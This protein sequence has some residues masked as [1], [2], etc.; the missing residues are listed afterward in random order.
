MPLHMWRRAHQQTSS[1]NA[2]PASSE[3]PR[4]AVELV[5]YLSKYSNLCQLQPGSP[6]PWEIHIGTKRKPRTDNIQNCDTCTRT[7][8]WLKGL[9]KSTSRRAVPL[10]NAM[11]M[12]GRLVLR[13][14]RSCPRGGATPRPRLRPIRVQASVSTR[15]ASGERT[16]PPW[17]GRAMF[18]D[19]SSWIYVPP[20][21]R[22]WHVVEVRV[23]EA[24]TQLV[25]HVARVLCTGDGLLSGALNLAIRT[26]LLFALMKMGAKKVMKTTAEKKGVPW[27]RRCQELE[28]SEVWL[29]PCECTCR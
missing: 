14:S 4:P 20:A 19:L 11:D 1:G 22:R 17:A 16:K 9:S 10:L 8:K 27:S 23:W 25:N 3:V 5:Y 26:P 7:R 6:M 29:F 12:G 24:G 21:G 28:K 15:D 2:T 13:S 18:C